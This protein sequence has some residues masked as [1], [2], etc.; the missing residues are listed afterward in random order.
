MKRLGVAPGGDG[1][2]SRVTV[3]V[4]AS[5]KVISSWVGIDDEVG[6]RGSAEFQVW[7]DGKSAPVANSGVMTGSDGARFLWADVTGAKTVTLLVTDGAD[8]NAYDHADW[9]EPTLYC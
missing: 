4:P 1:A 7:V 5:C 6:D 9:A 2:V 3:A 8:G